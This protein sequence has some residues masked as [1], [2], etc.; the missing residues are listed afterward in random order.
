MKYGFLI[1]VSMM[2]TV[3]SMSAQVISE[4]PPF[5]RAVSV[6]RYFDYDK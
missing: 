1:L 2:I 6:I 3:G 5:E 4:L